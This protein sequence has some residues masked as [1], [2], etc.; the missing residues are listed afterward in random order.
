M[1][2]KVVRCARVFAAL[3]VAMYAGA[4]GKKG[5]P[6]AP[7]VLIPASVETITT[8]RIGNDVFVTL[9][10]P[11]ANIDAST[12]VDIGKIEVYGYTGTVAPTPALWTELGTVVATISVVMP[13]VLEDGAPAPPGNLMREATVPGSDVTILDTLTPDELLQGPVAVVD[14]QRFELESMAVP[15][16]SLPTALRRFYIAIPFS[17]RE[18]PGPPGAEAG[19]VLTRLPDRPSDVRAEYA[20]TGVSLSW[21]PS[22]G[23]LGF[24][25]DLPLAVEPLP[26]DTVVLPAAA[27]SRPVDAS[28][29][30]GPTTYNMYRTI[31][32]DPFTLPLV[33]IPSSGQVPRPTP[34][35][36]SPLATTSTTDD[37]E[38]GRSRCYTVRAQ[39][40]EVMSEPS[41]PTCLTPIDIFPPSAPS[42]LAAVPSEGSISLVWEPST[43]LDLGGYLVLRQEAGD[44]TLQ[45]LTDMP[46]SEARYR[47]TSVQPGTQYTYSVVAIDTQ[48]P[49]PNTSAQSELV[50]EISR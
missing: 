22:G 7:F 16:V 36:P 14:Q 12:P 6:L 19:L 46:I 50:E 39:R 44:A 25:L 1:T 27:I 9:T 47:D 38:F 35:N 26:F 45:Q 31:A 30:P 29:P 32:P 49:L 5:P 18:R 34:F 8:S 28:V 11:L 33:S 10:V 23:L 2:P 4:C 37:V 48:L 24:L 13:P 42:G 17:Q 41:A 40:G 43:A 15:D 20:P 3:A 21:E